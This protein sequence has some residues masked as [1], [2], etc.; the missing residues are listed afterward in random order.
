MNST[1]N[2]NIE[3]KYMA[4]IGT[5][6][7]V[8]TGHLFLLRQLRQEADRAG[9]KPMAMVLDPHPLAIVRPH[10][11]PA[12]LCDFDSRKYALEKEGITVYRLAFDEATRSATSADF[13]RKISDELGV[14][15]LLVGYDN[16][17]GSDREHGFEYYQKIGRELGVDVIE[18]KC[19]PG[20]SS[21]VIR[22]ALYGGE[23]VSANRLLGYSYGFKGTVSHGDALGRELGFPTANITPIHSQQLI[24]RSGVYS[25]KIFV[26]GTDVFLP[27]MT[28]IGCRPTVTSGE[29]ELRIETHIFNFDENIYG[30]NV[31]L[32][33]LDR[34]RDELKFGSL[35]ELKA[36]LNLDAEKIKNAQKV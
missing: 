14:K 29:L 17:F 26:D 9:L 21:S 1:K 15:S 18:A 4:T 24:P 5:F 12:L 6:D 28:N 19:L 25:S 23:I 20:V 33:F 35:E 3:G 34:V 11:V 30:R 31:Q 16:R 10:K 2:V 8:H 13:L 7:G 32:H 27:S 22:Q 36:Q